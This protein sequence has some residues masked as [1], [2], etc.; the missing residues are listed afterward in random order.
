MQSIAACLSQQ[1]R[2]IST[3]TVTG[4]PKTKFLSTQ[5][6]VSKTC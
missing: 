2:T 6:F 5:N 1:R 4:T 3:R